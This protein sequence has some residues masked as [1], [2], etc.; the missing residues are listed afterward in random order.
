MRALIASFILWT[1]LWVSSAFAASNTLYGVPNFHLMYPS[2]TL[3]EMVLGSTCLSLPGSPLELSCNP[4]F[5][6]TEE[7]RQVRANLALN[8]RV[9]EVNKYRLLLEEEDTFGLVN[10]LLK[11]KEPLIANAA[12]SLWYQRDWWAIGVVPMRAGY[13]SFFRNSAYPEIAG[14]VFAEREIFAKAG[15]SLASDP[16]V[17]L[18]LQARY[19]ERDFFRKQFALLDAVTDNNLIRI[20]K[21]KALYLE[22]G[23]VYAFDD[24]A[25]NTLSATVTNVAVYQSGSHQPVR[26]LFDLGFATAPN[27]ADGKLKTSTHFTNNPEVND[28]FQLFRAGVVYDFDQVASISGSIAKTELGLG[29]NGRIQ[30]LILGVAYKTTEVYMDEWQSAR[31]STWLA[32]L[33][34]IF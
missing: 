15:L 21:Q 5:L 12:I 8:D 6:A 32:E 14:H 13:A 22:P 27:F 9:V 4:A 1:R 20:E 23:L 7:K 30:S 3:H 18:G 19:N 34:L 24:Q 16:R 33:G 26:P 17:R 29:V 25:R 28:P 31:V 2:N 11:E 10:G